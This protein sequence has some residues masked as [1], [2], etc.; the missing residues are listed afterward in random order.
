L[1]QYQVDVG[2]VGPNHM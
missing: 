2:R 1:L